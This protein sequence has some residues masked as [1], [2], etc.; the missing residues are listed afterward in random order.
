MTLLLTSSTRRRAM[1]LRVYFTVTCPCSSDEGAAGGSG[2]KLCR[3][4]LTKELPGDVTKADFVADLKRRVA[5]HVEAVHGHEWPVA[6]QMVNQFSDVK[7]WCQTEVS[8][9]EDGNE[10]T[11]DMNDKM[12][13]NTRSR[14]PIRRG[15]SASSGEAI[16]LRRVVSKLFTCR[17]IDGKEFKFPLNLGRMSMEFLQDLGHAISEEVGSRCAAMSQRVKQY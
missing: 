7:E 3:N 5:Q 8:Q 11:E 16:G 4:G 9:A 1:S 17:T 6:E 12:R 15:P 14:S 13:K 10:Y 2:N